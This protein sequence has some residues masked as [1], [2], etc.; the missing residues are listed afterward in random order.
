MH[1]VMGSVPSTNGH[2]EGRKRQRKERE[3]RKDAEYGGLP[4]LRQLR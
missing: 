1:K 2:G 4:I 3:R